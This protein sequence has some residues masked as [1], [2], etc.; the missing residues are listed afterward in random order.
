MVDEIKFDRKKR[1]ELRKL[2]DEAV[3]AHKD[4]FTF[5]GHEILVAY[6]KYLLEYLDSVL[7]KD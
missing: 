5:E 2:Y 6:A 4:K 7:G 3:K 1:D